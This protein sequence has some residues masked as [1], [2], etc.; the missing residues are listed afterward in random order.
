MAN[1]RAIRAH[2][3][4]VESTRK[5]TSSMRMVAA[6]KLKKAQSAMNALRPYAT[7]TKE[8]LSS[9]LGCPAARSDPFLRQ[10]EIG[11]VCYVLLIGDRGLCGLYNNALVRHMEYLAREEKRDYSVIVCG[12]WSGDALRSA[13]FPVTETITTLSDVPTA[14]E[15][16]ALCEKLKELYLSGGAD[17]IVL[18][19]QQYRSA[20]VQI[21]GSKRLLPLEAPV[22]EET[23]DLIVEP[24]GAA[25][26]SEL[27]LLYLENTLASV[28][29]EAKTGEHSAR[30]TAMT[31]AS[32]NTKEMLEELRLE[33]NH[34]RQSAI[35]TEISEIVGGANALAHVE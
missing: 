1:I 29:L 35:T 6:A 18:V 2:I 34:A 3:K 15:S 23:T 21:P 33:L 20:F 22:P 30:M 11:R 27:V 5:I 32:D 13:S 31:T 10:R 26:L 16:R 17:E 7:A 25:V 24:D 4:S 12:R 28:L 9:V 14:E 8:M 19:Y